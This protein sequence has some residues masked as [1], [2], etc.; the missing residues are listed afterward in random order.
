MAEE[1]AVPVD[2]IATA[3]LHEDDRETVTYNHLEAGAILTSG[4]AGGIEMLIID[5]S[6]TVDGTEL[7]K[8]AWL[9]LPEGKSLSAIAGSDGTKI[10][11]K[12]GHLPFAEKPAV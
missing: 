2:G 5:G 8:H 1:L 12:T 4:A 7:A 6:V 11:M 3:K 10:W 9:R